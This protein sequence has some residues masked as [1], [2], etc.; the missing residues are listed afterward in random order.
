MTSENKR[1][2][3]VLCGP[4]G[5]GK[6]TIVRHM[7]DMKPDAFGLSVSHTSRNIRE[8][9]VDGVHYH[10][11]SKDYILEGKENGEFVEIAQ[12]HK[13]Y[14]GTSFSSVN[15]VLDQNK[16]CILEIDIQG[17]Q[18]MKESNKLN[19]LY[20]FVTAS[21][22]DLKSR[23]SGRGTETPEQIQTRLETAVREFNFVEENPEFFDQIIENVHADETAEQIINW[24]IEK[25]YME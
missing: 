16:V 25:G 10:F 19:A 24:L 5:V 13:N 7:F 20:V 3:L 23:L 21:M 4:S 15:S 12:V 17:A 1:V 14:Y 22:D 8:G 18:T 11:V 6:G 9:E 2:A